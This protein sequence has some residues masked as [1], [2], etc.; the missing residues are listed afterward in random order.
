MVDIQRTVS[1][2]L[3][4]EDIA[5]AFVGMTAAEQAKFFDRVAYSAVES[6]GAYRASQQWTSLAFALTEGGGSEEGIRMVDTIAEAVKHFHLSPSS[7]AAWPSIQDP[8][9]RGG[10]FR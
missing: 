1:L 9:T 10:V 3:S 2:N 8:Q 5:D 4:P 6:W 7:A